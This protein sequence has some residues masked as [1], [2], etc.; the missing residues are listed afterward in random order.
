MPSCQP[1]LGSTDAPERAVLA[2]IPLTAHVALAVDASARWS[3]RLCVDR[4]PAHRRSV[5]GNCAISHYLLRADCIDQTAGGFALTVRHRIRSG[6]G[7]S[8]RRLAIGREAAGRG[9]TVR[10]WCGSYAAESACMH[11]WLD[12]VA[13]RRTQVLLEAHLRTRPAAWSGPM[14]GVCTRWQCRTWSPAECDRRHWPLR[15]STV[16]ASKAR[17]SAGLRC[18]HSPRRHRWRMVL[19]SSPGTRGCGATL[20]R[21][22]LMPCCLGNG[23]LR[24]IEEMSRGVDVCSRRRRNGRPQDVSRM[25]PTRISLFHCS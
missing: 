3:R 5:V 9:Q 15:T 12:A 21:L 8:R 7:H 22:Q 19:R 20:E 11:V 23:G 6:C 13:C 16:D 2:G 4:A 10:Y 24:R 1:G 14:G 25:W 17:T 18:R